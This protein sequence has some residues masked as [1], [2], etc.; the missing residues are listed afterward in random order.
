MGPVAER[1]ARS[2]PTPL[3]AAARRRCCDDDEARG[4]RDRDQGLGG[5]VRL[6]ADGKGRAMRETIDMLNRF[7]LDTALEVPAS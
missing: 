4:A 6:L 1:V 3:R 7:R 2:P 5:W